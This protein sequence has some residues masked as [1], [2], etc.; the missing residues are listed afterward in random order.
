MG[1]VSLRVVMGGRDGCLEVAKIV[2]SWCRVWGLS[3]NKDRMVG[4]SQG[5]SCKG[6]RLLGVD[7]VMT[8]LYGGKSGL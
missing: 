7:G 8:R 5:S 1:S 6:R 3:S 4:G 2:A